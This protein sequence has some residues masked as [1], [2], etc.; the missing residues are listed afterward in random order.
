MLEVTIIGKKTYGVEEKKIPDI[1]KQ[2]DGYAYGNAVAGAIAEYVENRTAAEVEIRLDGQYIHRLFIVPKG[3]GVMVT[4]KGA[5]AMPLRFEFTLNKEPLPEKYL[6]MVN[7]EKNNN[8]F[9]RMVDFGNRQWGAFYGRVGEAQGESR[10]STHIQKPHMYPDYMYGIKLFEKL[11]KGYKDKSECHVSG[12]AAP[13]KREFADIKDS[14][15]KQLVDKLMA[16]ARRTI[17]EN[18]TVGSDSVTKKMIEE[19]RVELGSLRTAETVEAFND[20][21]LEL[22]HTIPR[23]MDGVKSSG[24]MRMMAC[25][26]MD[27]ARII[28]REENLLSVMEGQ[29]RVNEKQKEET[30]KP[31]DFLEAMGLEIYPATKAQ[32]AEAARH[33]DGALASKLKAVYRVINKN[34]QQRFDNYLASQNEKPKVRLFWHGS[35]NCNWIHILQQGLL[36]NPDAAITGKMFGRGIYF[37]PSA[38]KSWGYTSSPMAKWTRDQADEA[39]MALYATAYGKPYEPGVYGHAGFSSSFGYEDLKRRA[40]G[41]SCVHAKRGV[42]GLMA[43]EVI[44]YRED[45]MTIKYLCE[46]T[47]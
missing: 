18:Y 43:D 31:T 44:F 10:Y 39:F 29:V 32:A 41:C 45:Q 3:D 16:Y 5:G 6:I 25:N 2:S 40:P 30:A 37:A 1:T 28:D 14:V 46:F 12:N 17:E 4:E 33:L 36:L 27:F 8:K 13:V 15:V 34:T 24:V 23:R 7:P 20:H 9:Y 35:K 47:S 19:A 11:S 42:G 22:M 21:L 26:E 38:T